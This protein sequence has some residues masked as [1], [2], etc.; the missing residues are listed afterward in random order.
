M[1]NVLATRANKLVICDT[2]PTATY[3]WHRR[4]LGNDSPL[5]EQIARNRRYDLYIL[6]EPDFEFVQDGTRESQHLR[7][8]M[9]Q[10]FIEIL[11]S[12]EKPYITVGGDRS[13]RMSKAI[14]AIDPLLIFP[15]L[16]ER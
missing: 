12:W 3:V 7:Q 13:N 11:E 8:L 2:D 5:V 10:Q 15:P 14:E 16:K 1:E 4:Y 9:H 6:T